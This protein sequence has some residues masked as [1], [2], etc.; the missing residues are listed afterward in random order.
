LAGDLK[1]GKKALRVTIEYNIP[2]KTFI[3]LLKAFASVGVILEKYLGIYKLYTW[4]DKPWFEGY[5]VWGYKGLDRNTSAR[6]FS[7]GS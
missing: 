4:F 2:V 1:K 6:R 5:K 7:E 3:S